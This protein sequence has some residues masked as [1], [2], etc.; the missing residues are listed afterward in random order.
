MVKKS[1]S[2]LEDGENPFSFLLS[3]NSLPA[4]R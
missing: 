4:H 3:E 2:Q 1:D